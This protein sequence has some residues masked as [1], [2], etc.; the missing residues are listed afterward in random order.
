[1]RDKNLNFLL[2][3]CVQTEL[4]SN[5]S[6]VLA[7]PDLLASVQHVQ[8]RTG[9]TKCSRQETIKENEEGSFFLD[10]VIDKVKQKES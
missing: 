1:M 3:H 10:V 6:T 8:R 4:W 5:I 7:S 9:Q 2:L